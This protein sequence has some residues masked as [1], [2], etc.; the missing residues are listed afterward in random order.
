MFIG[1]HRD[2]GHCQM[3]TSDCLVTGFSVQL[4]VQAA[5]TDAIVNSVQPGFSTLAEFLG[6]KIKH[7]VIECP[8]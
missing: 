4:I 8:N 3:N 5:A 6:I 7:P 1:D 2:H